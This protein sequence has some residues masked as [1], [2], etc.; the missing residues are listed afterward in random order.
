M[1]ELEKAKEHLLTGGYTCVLCKDQDVQVS[2]QR[3]VRPLV[4]WLESGQDF[5]GYYAADKVVGKA[6][7]FLYVLM[8]VKAVYAKVISQAALAVFKK[9]DIA[10]DYD[11]V[12]EYIINR[13]GDG[14]CP[15]EA[16]TLETDDAE[17]AY[18]IISAK[19]K[20]MS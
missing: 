17:A 3:G 14:M 5:I 4:D 9:Y 13:K 11:Q 1:M 15:F 7:A 2:R 19:L 6:T 12:V 8:G 18:A 10:V 16:A 20:Q